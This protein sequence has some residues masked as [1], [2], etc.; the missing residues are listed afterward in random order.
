MVHITPETVEKFRK[1][2]KKEYGVDYSD[3]E[4]WEATHNLLGAFEWLLE[5]DKKQNPGRYKR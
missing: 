5:Q 3:K 4:A 1:M 2:F